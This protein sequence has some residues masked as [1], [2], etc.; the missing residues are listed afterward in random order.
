[1]KHPD[2]SMPT[3]GSSGRWS[4]R[5]R[6]LIVGAVLIV[7]AG[8][9]VG[10]IT[11]IADRTSS[12][13]A[14]KDRVCCWQDGVTPDWMSEEIGIQIPQKA[15]D[16]RAGYK[17]GSRYDTGLLVFTLPTRDADEYTSRLIRE[18]TR[19]IR[20]FHPEKKGF[21][22]AD[23][24]TQ[25][26]LP[27]PETLVEGLRKISV[28]PDNLETPE[29]KHLRR[30]VDLFAHEFEPG[31]TRIYVKSTIEPGTSPPATTARG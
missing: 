3:I 23:G 1:M 10:G 26:D 16:R 12:N 2:M 9:I 7:V 24:F 21:R 20:N 6:L 30:C 11:L 29:G 18:G 14:E 28:C 19:M 17:T 5:N 25:L 15:S 27:E 22:P 8:T 13:Q 31:S 4:A